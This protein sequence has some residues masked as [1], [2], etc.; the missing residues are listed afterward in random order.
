[1]WQA[2]DEDLFDEDWAKNE[3]VKYN[4]N[5]LTRA[6]N[7]P[8]ILRMDVTLG[9]DWLKDIII[10]KD[11]GWIRNYSTLY[12]TDEQILHFLAKNLSRIAQLMVI[13]EGDEESYIYNTS[14]RF[15][16]LSICTFVR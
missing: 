8:T 7:L 1:M 5:I 13:Y 11:E 16:V 12:D 2:C 14:E 3:M 9:G 4:K 6:L 15:L 10:R